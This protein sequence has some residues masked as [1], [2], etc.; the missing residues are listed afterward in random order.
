MHSKS[1]RTLD[2]FKASD[3]QTYA[4]VTKL[5]PRKCTNAYGA[6]S[7][8]DYSQPNIRSCDLI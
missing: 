8:E 6:D 2:D 7:C 5:K 1:Y 3:V 4:E